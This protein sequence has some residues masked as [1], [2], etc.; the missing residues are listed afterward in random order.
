MTPEEISQLRRYALH[1]RERVA[2]EQ[3]SASPRT[4]IP[5]W[6]DLKRM[7]L[8]WADDLDREAQEADRYQGSTVGQL[9]E[10]HAET[11][12]ETPISNSAF[13]KI[14]ARIEDAFAYAKADKSPGNIHVVK[15]SKKRAAKK[16][17]SQ[18]RG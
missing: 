1:L 9:S 8:D 2:R 5:S 4:Q 10:G 17:A 13:E 12:D 3:R 6:V 16:K 15:V 18:K 14:M 11:K 7:L